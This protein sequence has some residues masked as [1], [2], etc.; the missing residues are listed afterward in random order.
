MNSTALTFKEVPSDDLERV[1]TIENEGYPSDEAATLQTFHKR[2]HQKQAPEL[3][4]GAYQEDQ[5]IGYICS[6]HVPGSSACIHSV[7]IS[8]SNRSKGVGLKLL[9]EYIARLEAAQRDNSAGYERILL[10]THA[11][12]RPFFEKAGFEWIGPSTVIHGSQPWYEMRLI[13]E[14]SPHPSGSSQS[15]PPGIFEALQ[16]PSRNPPTSRLLSSFPAGLAHVSS[17]SSDGPVNKFDLLCPRD[18]CGSVILKNGVAKLIE[19]ASV[20]MEPER[21]PQHPLLPAL[22]Q[23][24]SATHWWLI[25]PS[26]LEFENIGFSHAVD[27]AGEKKKLTCAEC[28]LGPLGWCKVG[29]TEFWLACSR[30]G[31]R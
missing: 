17:S 16:R 19:A 12:L 1:V 9:R 25:T 10:I 23:P 15:V 7:C 14:S 4:L 5:L 2:L 27:S 22:P 26:P 18:G 30:V 29:G 8:S 6:T 21:H 13:L 3:F 28:D 31:Y 11:N 24:P 20:Q